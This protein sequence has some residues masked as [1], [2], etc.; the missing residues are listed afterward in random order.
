MWPTQGSSPGDEDKLPESRYLLVLIEA[1][2][3]NHESVL[4][5]IC[6]LGMAQSLIC[7][8]SERDTQVF[9][10]LLQEKMMAISLVC[11]C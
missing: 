2:Q 6:L 4:E 5:R 9:I 11:F 8:T 10:G 3:E 1:N 7:I